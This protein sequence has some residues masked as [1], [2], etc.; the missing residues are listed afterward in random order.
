MVLIDKLKFIYEDLDRHGNVR[1]Y[2]WRGRGHRKIRIK[3]PFGTPAFR[4]A[5]DAA[6]AQDTRKGEAVPSADEIRP[7]SWRWLC[8]RYFKESSK[9]KRMGARTRLIR[10]QTLEHTFD[11][12]VA[13]G[14]A[15]TFGQVPVQFMDRKAVRVLRDRKVDVPNSGNNRL[16]AM[17]QV[18]DWAL[19]AE[20]PGIAGN[21][22]AEVANFDTGG[23]GWHTWTVEEVAAYEARHA[24]GSKARLALALMLFT[25]CRRSDVVTMGRQNVRDG[26]LTWV[27]AK[28]RARK[29]K[30][31]SVPILPDL[32]AELDRVPAG[33]MVFI[34]T[35]FGKPFTVNGFGN[36]FRKRCTEA[37]SPMFPDGLTLCSAHG[38][39]KAGAT[40]AAENGATEHQLMAIFGW[41]TPKQAA[42]YTRK[43]NRRKLAGNAMHMLNR[44][45]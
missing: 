12:P 9:Y 33:Q 32:Q 36:W 40:I 28:G 4:A 8:V 23:E 17:R 16:K 39:R 43:A 19:E 42:G 6:A 34:L 1:L 38:L 45:K 30:T 27:E 13:P 31:T 22:A 5:Y 14:D 44:T 24:P 20:V 29:P 10:K 21:V 11:E 3:E 15:R 2:F 7:G 37:T 35:E 41:T 25:G 26:W 18:F